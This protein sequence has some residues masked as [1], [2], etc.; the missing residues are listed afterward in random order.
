MIP[1]AT[2]ASLAFLAGALAGGGH[3]LTLWRNVQLLASGG[4][5]VKAVAF[6]IGRLALIVAV[7]I[8]VAQF[9]A[10]ALIF[11]MLGVLTARIASVRILGGM[12]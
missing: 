6:Q 10:L 2:V 11:A 5:P 9:G 3:Y 1:T 4:S 7:F 8:G 12:P